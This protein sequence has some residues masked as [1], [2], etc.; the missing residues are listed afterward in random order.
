MKWS[1]RGTF[2]YQQLKAHKKTSYLK[3]GSLFVAPDYQLSF[4]IHL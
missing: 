3:S 4:A 1:D 2:A